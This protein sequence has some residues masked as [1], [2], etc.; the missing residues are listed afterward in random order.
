[1][2]IVI[3]K[4]H[5]TTGEER[6]PCRGCTRECPNFETCEGKPW[7]QREAAARTPS[8]SDSQS[9]DPRN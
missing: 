2:P 5:Q 1:M 6:L 3:N 9:G 7:R 4:A 8:A